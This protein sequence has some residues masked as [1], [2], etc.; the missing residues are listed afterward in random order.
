MGVC[1]LNQKTKVKCALLA[2]ILLLL[3]VCV[4]AVILMFP[5]I[6]E[7]LFTPADETSAVVTMQKTSKAFQYGNTDVV[8]LTIEYPEIALT[9]NPDAAKLINE[10]I[11][12]RA[13][14]CVKVA[15][16]LYQDAVDSYNV[17]H[18]QGFPFPWEAYLQFRVTYNAHGLLSLYSD[19]YVYSG[20]AH[21]NTQR[22]S[23]TWALDQGTRGTLDSFCKPDADYQGFILETILKQA[24]QNVANDP[25]IMYFDNY[26]DLI[27]ENFNPQSFYLIPEGLVIYYQQY[28]VGPYSMGII[29]FTIPKDAF[30]LPN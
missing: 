8:K 25:E 3:V 13:D 23:A 10:E 12:L 7:A 6:R 29:E 9:G 14:E 30:A 18:Q 28:A 21:G 22:S 15:E 26:Q 24:Q 1:W 16:E 17:L 2:I 19:L 20:G 11:A 27:K 4:F 5:K